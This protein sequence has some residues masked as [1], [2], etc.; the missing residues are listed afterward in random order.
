MKRLCNMTPSP[1][2]CRV[3]KSC[4]TSGLILVI[5]ILHVLCLRRN[6][7]GAAEFCDFKH[8]ILASSSPSHNSMMKW[9][10]CKGWGCQLPKMCTSTSSALW[11]NPKLQKLDQIN[12]QLL[13]STNMQWFSCLA[14]SWH[15]RPVHTLTT[16]FDKLTK[17]PLLQIRQPQKHLEKRLPRLQKA[18][19]L[20]QIP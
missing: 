17:I 2:G 15:M 13:I 7:F 18:S 9:T 10:I 6:L 8:H 1:Q 20:N 16:Q 19:S 12:A 14:K 11:T 3:T 5:L 4:V